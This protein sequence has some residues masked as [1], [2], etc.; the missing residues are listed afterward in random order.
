M[1]NQELLVII[2][3]FKTWHHYLR[4][5]K[6]EILVLSDHNNFCGFMDNKEFELQTDLKGLEPFL[7]LLLYQLLSKE[8]K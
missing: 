5:C 4:N 7:I 8:S 6:Y 3:V 2:K 1:H